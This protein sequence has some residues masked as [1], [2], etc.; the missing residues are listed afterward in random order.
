MKNKLFFL[1]FFLIVV[2]S[3]PGVWAETAT[4]LNPKMSVNLDFV[5]FSGTP[6]DPSQTEDGFQ[7]RE[8]EIGLQ[9]DIDPY[10]RADVFIGGMDSRGGSPEVE[11]AYITLP[12]LPGGFQAR[13]GKFLAAFGRLNLI[14]PHE[15]PQVDAPL[16][17]PA[18]LGEEGL[19]SVGVEVSRLFTPGGLYGEVTYALLQDLGEKPSPPEFSV[20]VLDINGSTVTLP[21]PSTEPSAPQ[22]GRRFAHVGK[23]RIYHDLSDVWN[24]DVGVSGAVW[25]PTSS[26]S[27][28]LAAVDMTWRWNPLTGGDPRALLW[29]TEGM[30]SDRRLPDILH[31]VTLGVEVPGARVRARGGYSS[32]EFQW[33]RRWRGGLRG[34]YLEDPEARDESLPHITRAWAPFLTFAPTEFHR[35]RLQY[36]R[37][38]SPG[39]QKE[40]RGMVQ[41]TVVM[42]PHGAHPF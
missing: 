34:D 22:R 24:V 1:F 29:R 12:A 26:E 5:G 8:M 10:A 33:A 23:I 4:A 31:P 19:N 27:T 35:V 3:I 41:W 9:A 11:E 40:D 28:R 32:L 16:V 36:E 39:G 37:R 17:L 42:G 2:W 21:V 20:D 14:H 38:N 25:S 13:G 30:Y 18:F 7:L 6:G 15:Y